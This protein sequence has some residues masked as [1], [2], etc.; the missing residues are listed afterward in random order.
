MTREEVVSLLGPEGICGPVDVAVESTARKDGF[1]LVV[2]SYAASDGERV[3]ALL[4]LPW[5]KKG[6]LP[7]I[8]CHHQHGGRYDAGMTEPVGLC[9]NPANTFALTMVHAGFAVLCPEQI[10]FG[11]RREIDPKTGELMNGRDN[12]RWLFMHYYLIGRT[13]LGKCLRDLSRAVDALSFFQEVDTERIG[14]CGHSMGGLIAFWDGWYDLRIKAIFSCCGFSYLQLLQ[15]RH[16]N[17][18]FTMYLPGMLLHGDTPLLTDMIA[19]RPLYLTFGEEDH[20]FPPDGSKRII[21]HAKEVY[22]KQGAS[23]RFTGEVTP[24]GHI[25]TMEKQEKA[26]SFFRKWL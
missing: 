21:S 4:L 22:A 8:I 10:G 5:E 14:I 23:D 13:Y 20:I 2:F 24:D 9:E 15:D 6:K 12:E 17:H 19:P 3:K 7:L 16:I 11:Q 1:D 18:T 25:F 26:V